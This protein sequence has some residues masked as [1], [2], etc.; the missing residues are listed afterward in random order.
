MKNIDFDKGY[1][2]ANNK[3]YSFGEKGMPVA[4]YKVYERLS[5]E[6][7]FNVS[8]EDM[9]NNLK[10]I[11]TLST[12]GDETLKTT[13]YKIGNLSYNQM[14]AVKENIDERQPKILMLCTLFVNTKDEPVEWSESLANEKIEDW[15]EYDIQD[16]F[17]L[18]SNATNGFRERLTELIQTP[19]MKPLNLDSTSTKKSSTSDSA[20]TGNE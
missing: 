6:S 16:F 20:K 2:I 19:P 15:K 7:A 12:S 8:F 13:L 18:F 4:R 14:I 9:F 11:F 3:R 1:F 5:T 17:L 10:Q